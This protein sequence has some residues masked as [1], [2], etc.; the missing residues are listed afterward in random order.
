MIRRVAIAVMLAAAATVAPVAASAAAVDGLP[1]Y[2]PDTN[3]VTVVVDFNELGG[4]TVVRCAPGAQANGL[5]AL[6]NAGFTVQGTQRWGKAF[7]CRIQGKPGADTEACLNTPPASAYWSYWYAPNDGTWKYSDFGV[8]SRTPPAGSF[9]GWSFAK[10][11]TSSSVPP[12]GVAPHRPQPPPQPPPPPAA[13]TKPPIGGGGQPAAVPAAPTATTPAAPSDTATPEAT[14]PGT[15]AGSGIVT[16]I[17][18][19]AIRRTSTPWGAIAA[20]I[21]LCA[22]ALTA[23]V[24]RRRRRATSDT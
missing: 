11:K 2:C 6:E 17:A 21:L 19:P 9:E 18:E 10:D 4:G 20:A 1:G 15:P 7:I 12:P 24:I 8:L 22:L 13:T 5:T 14:Q 3:G 23:L 16:A